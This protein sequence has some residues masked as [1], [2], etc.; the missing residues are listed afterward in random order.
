VREAD[1]S[2]LLETVARERPVKTQQAVKGL[3][4]AVEISGG[5]VIACSSESCVQVVNKSNYQSIPR[6]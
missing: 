1:K 6:L 2:P 4:V 3:A 5:A